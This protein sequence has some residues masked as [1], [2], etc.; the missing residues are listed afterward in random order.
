MLL[1]R[2]KPISA[3]EHIQLHRLSSIKKKADRRK[4]SISWSAGPNSYLV[5]LYNRR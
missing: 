2:H 1:T 5:K 4:L 3:I